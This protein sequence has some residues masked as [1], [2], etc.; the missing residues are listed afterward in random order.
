MDQYTNIQKAPKGAGFLKV[1]G[2]LMIVFGAIGI[3]VALLAITALGVI[4]YASSGEISSGMAYFG[5][6]LSLVSAVAEL[7]AG[8]I[9]VV[10]CKKPEKANT[11]LAWGIIV[12]VLSVAGAI[13]TAASGQDFP[14]VSLLLGLVMPVLFIIGAIQNKKS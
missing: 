10:N 14:I 12:A 1:V 4:D 5:A 9:G 6:I 13:F 7:V 2:I 11:C 8:I 3:V